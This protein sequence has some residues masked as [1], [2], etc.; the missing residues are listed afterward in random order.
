MGIWSQIRGTFGSGSSDGAYRAD[1][2]VDLDILDSHDDASKLLVGIDLPRLERLNRDRRMKSH[3]AIGALT[4][5]DGN[6]RWEAGRAERS[7]GVRNIE[8]N[9]EQLRSIDVQSSVVTAV[10]LDGTN[11]PFVVN[12]KATVARRGKPSPK[13]HRQE[14]PLIS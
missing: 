10:L 11:V 5:E 8:L 1:A 7:C 13:A 3:S 4:I 12:T 2:S 6:L 9:K 14:P